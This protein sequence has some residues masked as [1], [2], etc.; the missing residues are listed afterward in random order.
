MGEGHNFS[1]LDIH[2]HVQGQVFIIFQ[3]NF[4]INCSHERKSGIVCIGG[5]VG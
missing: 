2:V 5:G 4:N 1:F 3:L